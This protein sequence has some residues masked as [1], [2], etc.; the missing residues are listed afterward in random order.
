MMRIIGCR[1]EKAE[2]KEWGGIAATL[3]PQ[4]VFHPSAAVLYSELSACFLNPPRV[5]VSARSTLIVGGGGKLQIESLELDGAL[6]IQVDKGASL[7]IRHLKVCNSGWALVPLGNDASGTGDESIPEAVQ[8][9][10]FQVDRK[11]AH[12]LTVTATEGER[13]VDDL[14]NPGDVAQ[15]E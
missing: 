7:I 11:G 14:I 2:E 12:K 9:R 10:C 4:I 1:V 8:I 6:L 3:G 5:A 15:S 13:I